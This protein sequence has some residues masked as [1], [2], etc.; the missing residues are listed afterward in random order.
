MRFRDT[1]VPLLIAPLGSVV[2]HAGFVACCQPLRPAGISALILIVDVW[3]LSLVA[4]LVLVLPAFALVP[5]SRTPRLW[6]AAIWGAMV[7]CVASRALFG[8]RHGRSS[9]LVA[10]A[11]ALAGAASGM[12][13]A[14]AMR[15]AR[16]GE[17]NGRLW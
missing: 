16:R 17:P 14:I 1:L 9:I 5:R 12:V 10:S 15:R 3:V 13:Y 7:A 2:V 8:L 4:A 6:V 11:T